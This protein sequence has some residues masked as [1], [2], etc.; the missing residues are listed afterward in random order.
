MSMVRNFIGLLMKGLSLPFFF[1]AFIAWISADYPDCNFMS[2]GGCGFLDFGF[3]GV[4]SSVSNWLVVV[5][6]AL[7]GGLL[8]ALGSKISVQ[9]NEGSSEGNTQVNKELAPSEMK[10]RIEISHYEEDR[11][12]KVIKFFGWLFL[13]MATLLLLAGTIGVALRDGVW[14]AVQLFNPFNVYQYLVIFATFA[15]GYLL[16][17]WGK[18]IAK[19][20]CREGKQKKPLS[21]VESESSV[22]KEQATIVLE[23]I[24]FLQHNPCAKDIFDKKILPRLK[25]EIA[26]SFLVEIYNKDSTFDKEALKSFLQELAQFQ[27]DIGDEPLR[28]L[29]PDLTK[30]NLS[31]ID[32][33]NRSQF[34][35]D[36]I[37]NPNR[38]RYQEVSIIVEEE[39]KQLEHLAATAEKSFVQVKRE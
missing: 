13:I 36:F 10:N 8:W 30:V 20:K 35:K 22:E 14:A 15:P 26:N 28:L 16:V 19:R 25:V 34:V 24:D 32:D 17:R 27:D 6:I 37:A 3:F 21:E 23:F 9:L 2:F 7:P 1:I 38:K 12:T 5:F 18:R 11:K 4:L 29:G 33:Q 31:K 39:R